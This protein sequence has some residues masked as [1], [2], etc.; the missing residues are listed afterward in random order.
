MF[1]EGIGL[2]GQ[3]WQPNQILGDPGVEA[4]ISHTQKF[5][6]PSESA[7]DLSSATSRHHL[8]KFARPGSVGAGWGDHDLF[9]EWQLHGRQVK[10]SMV[11]DKQWREVNKEVVEFAPASDSAAGTQGKSVVMDL[12]RFPSDVNFPPDTLFAKVN[13]IRPGFAQVGQQ[14]GNRGGYGGSGQGGRGGRDGL[15][16]H[17]QEQ[18]RRQGGGVRGW[19]W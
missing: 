3:E 1:A 16:R 19:G 17:A 12:E 10:K 9:R 7:T 18:L 5:L 6:P 13:P 15:K 4:L 2:S 11:V 8:E 14:G